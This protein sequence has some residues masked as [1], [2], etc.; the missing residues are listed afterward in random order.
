MKYDKYK[1]VN[2]SKWIP[3]EGYEKGSTFSRLGVTTV[4][5]DCIWIDRDRTPYQ[6]MKYAHKLDTNITLVYQISDD[7]V[8]F[9]KILGNSRNRYDEE[10]T[11]IACEVMKEIMT[12][13]E[14]Y[15]IE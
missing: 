5:K 8:K 15:K 9:V 14:K 11:V 12:E 2:D 13:Y 1:F 7:G 3:G 10:S 4:D 6:V